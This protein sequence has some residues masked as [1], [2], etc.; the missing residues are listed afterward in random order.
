MNI[1]RWSRFCAK[2]IKPATRAGFESWSP[3]QDNSRTGL[4]LT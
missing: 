1:L 4:S 3:W 2:K